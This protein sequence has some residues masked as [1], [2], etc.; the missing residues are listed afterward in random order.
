MSKS[1][2]FSITKNTEDSHQTD[3]AYVL[4]FVRWTNRDTL[5]MQSSSSEGDL[6]VTKP[7]VVIN[8]CVSLTTSMA[9]SQ[10]TQRITKAKGTQPAI[11]RRSSTES[12]GIA[13]PA[14]PDPVSAAPEQPAPPLLVLPAVPLPPL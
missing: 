8:D 14:P 2:T 11:C 10:Q 4:T 3:P 7:M 5:R 9:K 1:Y 12:S 6:G 13:P